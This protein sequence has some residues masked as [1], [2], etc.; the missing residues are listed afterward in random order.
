MISCVWVGVYVDF[1][2]IHCVL[3]SSSAQLGTRSEFYSDLRTA[4][5]ENRLL[6]LLLNI[7]SSHSDK[8][9][10]KFDGFAL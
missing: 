3:I 7:M 2:V 10:R 9:L 1:S 6:L 5:C 4:V 8:G